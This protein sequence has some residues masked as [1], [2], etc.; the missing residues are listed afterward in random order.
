MGP[1]EKALSD[2]ATSAA[3]AGHG[4]YPT[5]ARRWEG[6][7]ATFEST[8][9]STGFEG[10]VAD[11][12]AVALRSAAS[13]ATSFARAAD[14]V[15]TLLYEADA[16]RSRAQDALSSLPSSVAP[17]LLLSPAVSL[18]LGPDVTRAFAARREWV[19]KASVTQATSQFAAIT[20]ALLQLG[21]VFD[22]D[23]MTS[24]LATGTTTADGRYRIGPPDQPE[25]AWD[26]DF[27]YGSDD[28][29]FEDFL[30]SEEW[31]TKLLGA[32]MLRTDLADATA[33]YGHYWDN[34]GEPW[35]FDYEKA[36]REDG[37]V[38]A[39]VD[40]EILLAQRAADELAGSGGSSFSFTGE[41]SLTGRYPTT[42]NW[43]KAIGA[44]QQ[45]AS[46]DVVV[47]DG[48]ATMVVTV[49][50]DDRYNFNRGQSDIASAAPDDENGRFTEIGWA[51]PFD[52]TGS[53]TRTV[54]WTVGDPGSV[55]VSDAPAEGR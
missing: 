35:T 50:G 1:W 46:G 17:P 47:K 36:Y 43:Q 44:H 28:A 18:G 9:A 32:R 37:G 24:K 55:S 27:V 26:E 2:L 7:T 39:D 48:V 21:M 3:Y 14:S 19:A 52:S 45:W 5:A 29:T 22:P 8:A 49:H 20:P 15:P 6:A 16:I 51:K 31:K 23:V 11:A 34:D 4:S 25:Y 33:A 13:R 41:P 30:A 54:T 10:H 12:A 38:R 40:D 42:E 53:V